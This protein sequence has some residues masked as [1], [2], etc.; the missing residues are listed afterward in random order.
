MN[1]WVLI[2]KAVD[3]AVIDGWPAGGPPDWQYGEGKPIGPAYPRNASVIFS[4]NFPQLRKLH[5]FQPNILSA[6][7]V[8]AKA[9][10]VMEGLGVDNA[11]FLPVAVK[12]HAGEVVSKDYAFLNLLGGEDAIDLERSQVTMN[13]LAKDQVGDIDKLVL[14]P[15]GIRPEAKIFRCTRHRKLFL[16]REDVKAAFEAAGL[17]GYKLFAA[18]G[19]NGFDF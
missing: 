12:N 10:G 4:K 2:S 7:L 17:T 13:R 16:V 11:E 18:D 14:K 5:D 15:Q 3:G 1:Y 6:L 19:W 9:R 8:S